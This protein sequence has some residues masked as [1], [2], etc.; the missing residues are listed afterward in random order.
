[1]RVG[2]DE[3]GEHDTAAEIEF[4]RAARASMVLD[5]FPR[6][7]RG[8]AIAVNEDRPVTNEAQLGKAASAARNG[9]A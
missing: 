2:V 5:A 1:M 6:A 8:D 4:F 9:T 7:D 3:A